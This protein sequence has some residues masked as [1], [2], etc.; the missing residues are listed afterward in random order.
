MNTH[1]QI[2]RLQLKIKNLEK[3]IGDASILLADY[4]GYYDPFT[5]TGDVR[6]LASLI[7]DAYIIL[8]GSH[9]DHEK[10]HEPLPED[11]DDIEE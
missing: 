4:D 10:E 8:Q 9:W 11:N 5:K 2:Q 6:E 1:E 3:R 7:D